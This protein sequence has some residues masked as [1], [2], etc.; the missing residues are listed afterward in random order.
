ML[1]SGSVDRG[2]ETRHG[3]SRRIAHMP[4]SVK[5]LS[6]LTLTEAIKNGQIDT[7]ILQQELA[8]VGPANATDF[9]LHI[10]KIIRQPQLVDQTSRLP[11]DDGSTGT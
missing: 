2:E 7:F 9:D 10:E 5:N 1:P 6:S 11:C 3:N 8:G 4:E